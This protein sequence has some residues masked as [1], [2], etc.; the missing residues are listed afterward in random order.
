[1]MDDVKGGS[2][3]EQFLLLLCMVQVIRASIVWEQNFTVKAQDS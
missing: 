1:M 2:D 3:G